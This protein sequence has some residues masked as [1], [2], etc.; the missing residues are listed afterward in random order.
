MQIHRY[1]LFI[2]LGLLI[3]HGIK[4]Q[5]IEN[6]EV[7]RA[8]HL[9]AIRGEVNIKFTLSTTDELKTLSS[10]MSIDRIEGYLVEA[11]LNVDQFKEFLSHDIPFE[12]IEPVIRKK[13]DSG[14]K[15]LFGSGNWDIYPGYQQYDSI[16]QKFAAD[17]PNLCQLVSIGESV[18]GHEIL[19]LKISD[20]ANVDEPEPEFMYS[21]TMHGDEVIGYVLMMRLIDHLL[22]GYGSDERLTMLVDS[23][24]IW[25]NPLANPDG[26]YPNT[27]DGVVDPKRT[28]A[29]GYDLN[30]NFLDP[31]EGD[32][33]DPYQVETLLMMDFIGQHDFVMSANLHG[34]A[35]VVNYPWD[36]W[37]PVGNC[38]GGSSVPKVHADDQWFEYISREYADTAQYYSPPGYLTDLDNGITNG[39]LWYMISGG[40][41]DYITYFHQ[42]R[43]VTL[44]L[45][46]KFPDP[47]NLPAY[48]EYNY[49]SL[50]TYM[51][52]CIYGLHGDVTNVANGNPVR[53]KIFI[54]G[55]DMDSSHV[56]SD[57]VSGYYS[58]LLIA[59]EYDLIVSADGYV[60]KGIPNITIENRNTLWLDIKLDS[61]TSG[62]RGNPELDMNLHIYP[63]PTGGRIQLSSYSDVNRVIDLELIDPRGSI[64]WKDRRSF[65]AG[66]NI[67]TLNLED[68]SPGVYTL[69]LTHDYQVRFERILKY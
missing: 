38:P 15:G 39:A 5:D 26:T 64:I 10:T 57:S 16:M 17:Y 24:E 6:S 35:E 27:D 8:N 48:W 36:T 23:L 32:P 33:S 20:N 29:M 69:K 21:S 66:E 42:G 61:L 37:C 34:G 14:S 44:E 12:V 40:R 30:R 56:Y 31:E 55:H 4:G 59:G 13:A 52:Q 3:N 50:L 47:A 41:Q 9:L 1:L 51:E 53:A 18:N 67:H 25:I 11:Y 54:S 7:A 62:I 19:F 63:N 43:E 2:L 49:R 28:N 45:G 46:P 60:P 65:T 22:T 68:L 58:R